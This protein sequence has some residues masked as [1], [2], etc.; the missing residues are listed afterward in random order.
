MRERLDLEDFV[1]L[2][3]ACGSGFGDA[4]GFEG[5]DQFSGAI[6]IGAEAKGS[7]SIFES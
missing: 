2:E 1:P 5:G 3:G 7:F 6:E 4:E